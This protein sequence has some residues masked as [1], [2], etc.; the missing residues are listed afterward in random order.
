MRPEQ[1]DVVSLQAFEALFDGANH[2]LAIIAGVG[3]TRCRCRPEG[4]F[5]GDYQAIPIRRDELAEHG[6]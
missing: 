1:I 6:F 2:V 5:G 3:N 4:V